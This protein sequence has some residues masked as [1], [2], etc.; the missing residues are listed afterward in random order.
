MD[1]ILETVIKRHG[2]DGARWSTART[3]ESDGA[4][5]TA[6]APSTTGARQLLLAPAP[7]I[8]RLPSRSRPD[9]MGALIPSRA[10]S[11]IQTLVFLMGDM[12]RRLIGRNSSVFHG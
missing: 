11:R 7:V 9:K 3:M 12:S 1:D 5:S 8:A 10:A 4:P 2:F 6:A